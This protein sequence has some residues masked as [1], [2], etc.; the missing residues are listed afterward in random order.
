MSQ[1][2]HISAI[3]CTCARVEHLQEALACFLE[4]QYDGKKELLILNT[5][6]GQT[7]VFEHPEVRIINLTERPDTLG[8]ARN[9][10]I[11]KSAGELMVTWDDDDLYLPHHL[12]TYGDYWRPGHGWI[13]QTRQFFIEAW[14][15]TKITDG[16]LNTFAFTKT[17]WSRAG[18]YNRV[19]VGEDKQIVGKITQEWPGERIPLADHEISFLYGWDNNIYHISGQGEAQ[20]LTAM[21]RV[22]A[23][24]TIRT[25]SG[26]EPAGVIHLKPALK[27]NYVAMADRFTGGLRKLYEA[28]RGKVGLVLLGRYGDILNILPVAKAI[29]D[30]WEKPH[31]YVARQF[32]DVLDGVSYVVPVVVDLSFEKVH[33]AVKIAGTQCEHVLPVQAWGENWQ[34]DRFRG[35]YNFAPWAT[36][37]FGQHFYDFTG[38]PLVLDRRDHNRETDLAQTL[39]LAGR[40]VILINVDCGNSSP[41]RDAEPFRTA[42][43]NQW[44]GK[45][46]NVVNLCGVKGERIYDL[47]GVFDRAVLLITADTAALHLA[48]ACSKLPVVALVNDH[49][50]GNNEWLASVPRCRCVLR[51]GYSQVMAKINSVNRV[52]QELIK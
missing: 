22:S 16:C 40:P 3:C 1:L 14:R 12:A 2:P 45:G 48:A 47:L 34:Q 33:E 49:K 5:W 46:F 20:N 32:A 31:F 25:N 23:D 13:H 17:A 42:I 6:P 52:I 41:F 43:E 9:L 10:A 21:E 18:G 4:Q 29:A 19:N 28:K 11:S 15:I 36:A 24:A 39:P 8:Q 7:L 50:D 37:G 27:N 38:F 44:H 30:R 35:A 51:I 26:K